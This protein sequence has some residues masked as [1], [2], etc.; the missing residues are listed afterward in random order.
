MRQAEKRDRPASGPRRIAARTRWYV[1]GWATMATVVTVL[2]LAGAGN[3][4][5]PPAWLLGALW[6][7]MVVAG[8]T[9]VRLSLFGE[10]GESITFIEVAAV[11]VMVLVEPAWA[12][13]VTFCAV[14]ISETI[15]TP[16]QFDKITY[17][18]STKIVSVGVGAVAYVMWAG[19]GF[20][21]SPLQV[22]GAALAGLLFV[23][24]NA[25]AFT[26]LL[27]VAN[28]QT[29]AWAWRREGAPMVA[30]DAG[31]A[32]TGVLVVVLVTQAPAALPLLGLPVYLDHLRTRARQQRHELAAAKE[33]AEAAN[34]AK[35]TFLSRMSHEVRTPLNIILG[36][37]QL[38]EIDPDL[39]AGTQAKVAPL[40]RSGRHLQGLIEELLD[41]TRIETGNLDL[42]M[43]P[44][45]L[46]DAVTASVEMVGPLAEERSVRVRTSVDGALSVRVDRQ[47][48]SQVLLNLLSNAIKYNHDGGQVH[49][50]ARRVVDRVHIDVS[51]TGPGMTDEDAARVFVPFERLGASRTTVQG[52]GLGLGISRHLTEAMGGTLNV[53]SRVGQGSTFTVTLLAGRASSPN[54][55]AV[56]PPNR[57]AGLDHREPDPSALPS[58]VRALTRRSAS[59]DCSAISSR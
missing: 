40:M 24:V 34:Q 2:A 48:L 42:M 36:F 15:R 23:A 30:L 4:I 22:F 47:R 35:S 18:V 33:A 16:G 38:L 21:G 57:A 39:D 46:A 37:G 54:I 59:R 27:A 50:T 28:G 1:A 11:P 51:D 32:A 3:G 49:V 56:P 6:L 7:T 10:V 41:I 14:V 12:V 20:E 8:A 25:G 19:T 31:V 13:V 58:A 9:S 55:P 44:V 53:S 52:T 29:W 26:G 17:N 5:R 45:V 43:E